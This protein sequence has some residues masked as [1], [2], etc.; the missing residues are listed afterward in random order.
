[1]TVLPSDRQSYA[2]DPNDYGPDNACL[3]CFA[4]ISPQ[5][6]YAFCTRCGEISTVFDMP[7]KTKGRCE[8]HFDRTAIGYCVLCA[9]P[10]C[11]DCVDYTTRPFWPPI[12][13]HH[14]KRCVQLAKTTEQRFFDHLGASGVCAKHEGVLAAHICKKCGLPLCPPCA[15]F[16]KRGLLRVHLGDGPYCLVCFRQTFFGHD[17]RRWLPGTGQRHNSHLAKVHNSERTSEQVQGVMSSPRDVFIIF[18]PRLRAAFLPRDQVAKAIAERIR[19][20]AR[21]NVT[22]VDCP[23]TETR[24]DYRYWERIASRFTSWRPDDPD[25][26][27]VLG[28]SRFHLD[29]FEGACKAYRVA[30]RF[31]DDGATWFSLGLCAAGDERIEAY[32]KALGHDSADG[33]SWHYLGDAFAHAGNHEEAIRC[34]KTAIKY[35][36]QGSAPWVLCDL[37]LCYLSANDREGSIAAFERSVRADEGFAFY[38]MAANIADACLNE[39]PEFAHALHSRVKPLSPHR[40]DFFLRCFDT[41][42]ARK[43]TEFS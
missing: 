26:W 2:W 43:R 8:Y 25:G 41:R 12:P 23:R 37:G 21:P 29:D 28:H 33:M 36:D 1:M 13:R 3:R 40:A 24:S 39:P 34:F 16:R 4:P 10:I 32:R 27:I 31:K 30:A 35:S 17:R 5:D 14:C 19:C 7:E 22:P 6:E 42:V 38:T 9:K 11:S 15:C 18:G 20:C